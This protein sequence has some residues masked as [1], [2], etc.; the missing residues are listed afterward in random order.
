MKDPFEALREPAWPPTLTPCIVMSDARRA[1]D[2]YIDVLGAQRRGGLHVNADGTIG[3]AE[4]GTG[5][6]A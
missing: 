2:W 3:H 5:D 4:A 1:V 6:A